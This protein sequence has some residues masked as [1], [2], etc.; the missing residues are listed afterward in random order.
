ME[1]PVLMRACLPKL[2]LKDVDT[3]AAACEIVMGEG[4][5]GDP[6]VE[7]RAFALL[8]LR[9]LE[10][11]AE[12]RLVADLPARAVGAV[13]EQVAEALRRL[14]AAGPGSTRCPAQQQQSSQPDERDGQQQAA[15]DN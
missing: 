7:E 14:V 1:L 6:A 13:T 10:E 12:G 15:A 4:P 11:A 9:L 5:R 3:L 8:G 2:H